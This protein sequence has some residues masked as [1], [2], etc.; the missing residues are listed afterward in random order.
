[1]PCGNPAH[2]VLSE[3]SQ[4]T[5]PSHQPA[6]DT[7][8]GPSATT[9]SQSSSAKGGSSSTAKDTG[10]NGSST[11][12]GKEASELLAPAASL[13]DWNSSGS[14]VPVPP[15][16]VAPLGATSATVPLVQSGSSVLGLHLAATAHLGTS[17]QAPASAG[18]AELLRREVDLLRQEVAALKAQVQGLHLLPFIAPLVAAALV[19]QQ[20]Q[21][22]QEQQREK[23]ERRQEHAQLPPEPQHEAEEQQQQHELPLS[24]EGLSAAVMAA[25]PS[26]VEQTSDQTAVQ[27]ELPSAAASQAPDH[28]LQQVEGMASTVAAGS[29][30]ELQ[31][32]AMRDAEAAIDQ[33]IE[34]AERAVSSACCR[35]DCGPPATANTANSVAAAL[36]GD[37]AAAPVAAVPPGSAVAGG[38]LITLP[39]PAVPSYHCSAAEEESEDEAD[40]AL[41]AKYGL[42]HMGGGGSRGWRRY[43]LD[44]D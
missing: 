25:S 9:A 35:Q 23:E 12:I 13:T 15:A 2:T 27:E 6:C 32:H 42:A 8:A 17:S 37:R 11:C 14:G 43:G 29:C 5:E 40:A 30:R 10:S 3:G 31:Q 18:S 33:L 34:A 36:G 7:A 28:Q 26:L 39:M 44:F 4:Q 41:L 16:G 24:Q 22:Q 19:Q 1:M 38:A 21:Q 20:Q